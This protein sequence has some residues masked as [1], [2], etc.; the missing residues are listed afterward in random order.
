MARHGRFV[1]YAD[2]YTGRLFNSVGMCGN[3]DDSDTGNT[4]IT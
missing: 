1:T 4:D 3:L 2:R